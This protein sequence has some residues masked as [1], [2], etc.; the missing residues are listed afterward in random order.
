MSIRNTVKQWLWGDN[1]QEYEGLS[2]EEKIERSK[3]DAAEKREEFE[4]QDR[5]QAIE[6][7]GSEDL[8]Q[9]VRDKEI[10]GW[11][12]DRVERDEGRVVMQRT[13]SQSLIGHLIVAVLTAWWSFGLVNFLYF[14]YRR[15]VKTEKHV[16]REESDT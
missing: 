11:S 2:L 5:E 7:Y 3:S 9:Q 14:M 15:R 8:Y 12:V 6:K 10:E 16:L 13:G 4:Q 1:W